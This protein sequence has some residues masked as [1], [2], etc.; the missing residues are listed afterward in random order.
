MG[1]WRSAVSAAEDKR[2]TN[3]ATFKPV[4]DGITEVVI[5]C[6]PRFRGVATVSWRERTKKKRTVKIAAQ[7]LRSLC[8][9]PA[10]VTEKKT[11]LVEAAAGST[12]LPTDH[13]FT[14]KPPTESALPGEV[15]DLDDLDDDDANGDDAVD[16]A[17]DDTV[18][19]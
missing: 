14:I 16:D 9:P 2:E 6:D 10:P 5:T 3:M 1:I 15:D 18:V 8:A 4:V 19:G 13:P 11:A 17:V 7:L 12:R